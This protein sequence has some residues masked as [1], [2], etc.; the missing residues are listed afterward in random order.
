[1]KWFGILK[2]CRKNVYDISQMT[3]AEAVKLI[4]ETEGGVC[5]RLFRRA[6]GT[7]LTSDCPKGLAKARKQLKRRFVL[8]A[9]CVLTA[10]GCVALANSL[11]NPE[12]P[13]V[14]VG[15]VDMKPMTLPVEGPPPLDKLKAEDLA[16]GFVTLPK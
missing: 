3:R 1:M 9:S 4:A 12:G 8:V 11:K 5:V 2:A 13:P 7:V 6:D 16:M 15:K 10:L 14:V